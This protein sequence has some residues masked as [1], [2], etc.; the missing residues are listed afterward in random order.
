M[1][2]LS[3]CYFCG[4]VLD[5][6]LTEYPVVPPSLDP[7]S[8]RSVVLCRGCARKLETVLEHVVEAVDAGETVADGEAVADEATTNPGGG[9]DRDAESGPPDLDESPHLESLGGDS[10][11]RPEANDRQAD[12]SD[13]T[14]GAGSPSEDEWEREWASWPG[15]SADDEPTPTGDR[16]PQTEP[17]DPLSGPE[18]PDQPRTE[19]N[20][21]DD[22]ATGTNSGSTSDG[23]PGSASG[24]REAGAGATSADDEQTMT[25][26]EYNRVMRLIQNRAFPVDR[27]EI[28]SV[29]ANA[30]ELSRQDCARVIDAAIDR[31]LLA[32][33][34]G[35]LV[36]PDE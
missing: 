16:A 22:P 11:D 7:E 36:A 9:D 35:K 29:A 26:L 21:A 19:P 20:P 5:E 6:P 28:E 8:D 32:E 17:D 2:R 18:A 3:S 34:N 31:G 30:Y 23:G 13:G 14:P 15:E 1:D 24:G 25:A 33:S 4:S 27:A 10:R 12:A